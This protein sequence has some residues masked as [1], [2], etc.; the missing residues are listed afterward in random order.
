M[1]SVSA[2]G[3]AF[4]F[5]GLEGRAPMGWHAGPRQPGTC[6]RARTFSRG[7]RLWRV[8][9]WEF[10]SP[11]QKVY[12]HQRSHRHIKRSHVKLALALSTAARRLHV[13]PEVLVLGRAAQD[14]G[15]L[16]HVRQHGDTRAEGNGGV[17]WSAPCVYR[18]G[19][20][21]VV[22]RLFLPSAGMQTSQR[23][24]ENASS[25]RFFV[26]IG[27]DEFYLR[28]LSRGGFFHTKHAS[29]RQDTLSQYNSLSR[30]S[31]GRLTR[32]SFLLR[33]VIGSGAAV[34]PGGVTRC[35]D[36]AE[37]TACAMPAAGPGHRQE[38][39]NRHHR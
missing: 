7:Q 13:R 2:S 27:E 16:G 11:D 3:R 34:G 21:V 32:F 22:P 30:G 29:P 15:R 9:F 28:K 17:K 5:R 23:L 12:S 6:G 25:R 1:L 24:A 36:A 10:S 35:R 20:S 31:S 26:K 18:R 14:V 4:L 19:P 39:Q 38:A 8:Y 33:D 37:R